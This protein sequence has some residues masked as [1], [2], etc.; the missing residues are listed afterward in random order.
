MATQTIRQ[1][2]KI[3]DLVARDDLVD[4]IANLEDLNDPATL[5]AGEFF[6]RNHFTEGLHRLLHTGF[7][8]L[9][10]RSDTRAFYL[11]QSMGGGKTHSL[12]AFGLLARDAALRQRIVPKLAEN[13]SFGSAKI[14]VFNGHQNPKH[15]LWGHIAEQLGRPEKMSRFWRDGA[16]APGVDDW[17]ATIGT[18]PVLILLDELPSYLQMTSGRTVGEFYPR[19]RH[20]RGSRTAFNALPKLPHACVVVTNL[21]DDIYAQGSGKLRTLIDDLTKQYDKFATAITPVQQNSAEVFQIIRKKLFDTLPSDDVVADL[22]QS[23]VDVLNSAKKIDFDCFRSGDVHLA[24]SGDLSLSSLNSRHR[25]AVQGERRISA[26]P[27]P[28]PDLR[29]AVRNAMSSN[30]SI[31]LIGLQHLDFNDIGTLEEVRKINPHFSNAI[32]KDVADQGNALAERVDAKVGDGTGGRKADPHVI[33]LNG[34]GPSAE[35]RENEIVEYAIDPLVKVY[36]I[37][38]AI[39]ELSGQG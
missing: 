9:S 34:E 5:H 1:A 29:L 31:F 7:E 38:N 11:S 4:Q 36:E 18:D 24:S 16:D 26:D 28:H 15:F 10:G 39:N 2:C 19:R 21:K 37:K 27:R 6:R 17:I 32:S 30:E 23:Y 12:I 20:N 22:A 13:A 3:S 35:L 8:R 33:P 14:V 25:S